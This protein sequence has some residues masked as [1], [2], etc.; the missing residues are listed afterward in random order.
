MEFKGAYMVIERD[1]AVLVPGDLPSEGF[2]PVTVQLGEGITPEDI[3]TDS[4]ALLQSPDGKTLRFERCTPQDWNR[5]YAEWE[6]AGWDPIG[7]EAVRYYPTH[8][9]YIAASME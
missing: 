9:D 8:Q 5:K 1:D 6:G 7:F 4:V 3:N 2:E